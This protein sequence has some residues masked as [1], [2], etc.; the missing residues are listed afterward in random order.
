MSS[1]SF[2]REL[3]VPKKMEEILSDSES[4]N[5]N[6]E[7]NL[8][9]SSKVSPKIFRNSGYTAVYYQSSQNSILF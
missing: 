8:I 5:I 1:Y 6:N 4:T 7:L 3:P 2:S 9:L